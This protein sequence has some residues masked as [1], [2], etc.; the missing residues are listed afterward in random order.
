MISISPQQCP[1]CP[2]WRL[3]T[4]LSTCVS[5]WVRVVFSSRSVFSCSLFCSIF[6]G[7]RTR[8]ASRLRSLFSSFSSTRTHL[9]SS[10]FLF[11]LVVF[12]RSL[13]SFCLL[14]HCSV[15]LRKSSFFSLAPP[16]H[17]Q[18]L[19]SLSLYFLLPS[20]R[21]RNPCS[22]KGSTN[23]H[24]HTHTH[25]HNKQTNKQKK[26]TTNKQTR[27]NTQVRLQWEMPWCHC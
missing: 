8:L 18:A 3:K 2:P 13:F 26:T 17:T 21:Q 5:I 16:S 25:A 24:T 1:L 7:V 11:S 15:A 14:P 20:R 10:G 9:D 23:T 19:L 12:S 6:F 27:K 4:W 22:P